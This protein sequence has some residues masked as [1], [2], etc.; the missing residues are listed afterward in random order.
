MAFAHISSL[1]LALRYVITGFIVSSVTDPEAHLHAS[2]LHI[3][4]VDRITSVRVH[5]KLPSISAL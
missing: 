1:G 3:I 5:C 4:C 2:A